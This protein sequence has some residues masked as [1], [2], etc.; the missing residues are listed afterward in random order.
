MPSQKKES[1]YLVIRNFTPHIGLALMVMPPPGKSGKQNKHSY[2]LGAGS[3]QTL[4]NSWNLMPLMHSTSQVGIGSDRCPPDN[5][6]AQ[7]NN[8]HPQRVLKL[9]LGLVQST[10]WYQQP[11]CRT[12]PQAILKFRRPSG[13]DYR[14]CHWLLVYFIMYYRIRFNTTPGFYFSKLIFGWGSIQIWLTWGCIQAGAL[15]INTS[16]PT[17]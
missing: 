16:R 7:R 12:P 9:I 17:L 4:H 11:P 13:L 8:M 3:I 10:Q 15:I 14:A 5:Y 1:G 2:L 6:N